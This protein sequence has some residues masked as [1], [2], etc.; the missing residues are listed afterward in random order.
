LGTEIE[1]A[2][3][4]WQTRGDSDACIVSRIENIV[5]VGGGTA[6]W[7]TAATIAAEFKS[8]PQGVS[9][10]LVESPETA[11]IGVG[12]GT[13]P[14]MRST[15]QKIG[16]SETDFIRECDA[17][18]KQGS[19][20]VGWLNGGEEFYYHP[21]SLPQGYS[22]L[23]LAEF[24]HPYRDKISF[25][26]AVSPQVQI[27]ERHAAPKQLATPEYAYTLNYGYHLDA[28]KFAALLQKH[29]VEKLG[30][31]HRVDHIVKVNDKPDGDIASI[32]GREHGEIAADLFVDCSGFA[33]L[34]LGQHFS[35]PFVDRSD[36]LFN[37][38]ALAVQVPYA[39]E[40]AP[41]ASATLAT[42]R[43]AG[44][45]WDIGLPTRRGTGYVYSSQHSSEEQARDELQSYLAGT[46]PGVP[47]E[48]LPVRLIKISP[49]HRSTFWHKN[50]VAIG[51][52]AGFLEPLE[53]SALVL[54]EL[55]ARMLA[56][57]MPYNRQAMDIIARKYNDKFLFRW[58]QV[59]EFLKLHYVLS[60]RS[61]SQ[62]WLDN[63]S[64]ESIPG[65]L[66]EKLELWRFRSPW[67]RDETHVD[68]MFPSASYQYVLYGMDF[69]TQG[70]AQRRRAAT[71]EQ[72]R[73]VEFFEANK[74]MIGKMVANLPTNRELLHK[75]RQQG[76]SRI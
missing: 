33:S 49:G 34:L 18:F 28:L 76:F 24:W 35:I 53:A 25:A 59:I 52:S 7:L 9:V 70:S 50:C 60:N 10:T 32:Q 57:Q 58:K 6:G 38:R 46:S 11:S 2:L 37:D 55:G 15:L 41:I 66:A 42:A 19:K 23:N 14:S 36:V 51:M 69:Q 1:K 56:E 45:I 65:E 27:C 39:S 64:P 72:Q 29:A 63:R 5:I 17:S 26:D 21:F 13:W 12:E 73:A 54:V 48:E 4:T 31:I 22:D 16:I 74:H 75:V 62:Y 43:R 40:E 71:E 30:V 47:I 20:F 61:D 3:L 68:E 67:H 8:D 44:W